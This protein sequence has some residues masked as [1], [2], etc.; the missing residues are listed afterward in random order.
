MLPNSN[1]SLKRIKLNDF[2]CCLTVSKINIWMRPNVKQVQK[3]A[4]IVIKQDIF[5]WSMQFCQILKK[6]ITNLIQCFIW[7]TFPSLNN[8]DFNIGKENC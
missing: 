7:K 3:E 5:K 1:D 6:D 8:I 4:T 2:K